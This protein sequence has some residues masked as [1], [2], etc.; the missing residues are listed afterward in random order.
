MRHDLGL[1]GGAPA[2]WR[3]ALDGARSPRLQLVLGAKPAP[4]GTVR[5]DHGGCCDGL[6]QDR[7]NANQG[8]EST[9]SFLLALCELR[10][11]DRSDMVTPVPREVR[12][13]MRIVVTRRSFTAPQEPHLDRRRLA[14]SGAQRVQPGRSVS[15]TA[16]PC[17]S[18]GWKIGAALRT[19]ARRDQVMASTGGSWTRSRRSCPIRRTIPRNY[20]VSKIRALPSSTN[21]ANTPS[22]TLRIAGEDQGRARAHGGF[23]HLRTL[24]PSHA[25]GRQGRRLVIPA[26]GMATSRSSTGRWPTRARMVWISFS[27][28]LRNWGSHKLVL[29]ARRGAWWDAN[30]VGLSP[31]SSRHRAVG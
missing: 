9:L 3:Q 24:W 31:R 18:A 15:R 13:W 19:F 5:R 12:S 11:A 25:T 26:H 21:S 29:Q 22:H 4:A 16:K 17:C 20:G 23:S 7:I 30:K 1:H 14:L 10:T 27:P 28:D 8:A 2:H 6:H